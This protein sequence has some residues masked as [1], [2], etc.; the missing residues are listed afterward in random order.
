MLHRLDEAKLWGAPTRKLDR[1]AAGLFRT[2]NLQ[3]DGRAEHLSIAATR[4]AFCTSPATRQWLVSQEAN[5]LEC[6][7]RLGVRDVADP[8]PC[9]ADDDEN[10]EST[11]NQNQTQNK[12][13]RH[14]WVSFERASC[15]LRRREPRVTLKNGR[16]R[17]PDSLM[18][19]VLVDDFRAEVSDALLATQRRLKFAQA[20]A[21]GGGAFGTPVAMDIITRLVRWRP[22]RPTRQ[23]NEA[24]VRQDREAAREAARLAG[25]DQRIQGT[26]R[27]LNSLTHNDALANVPHLPQP[28]T[29]EIEDL[30]VDGY[31]F[32]ANGG[33]GGNAEGHD[34]RVRG[35]WCRGWR[36]RRRDAG[37]APPA[38]SLTTYGV[39][40]GSL[41]QANDSAFGALPMEHFSPPIGVDAKRALRVIRKGV[42]HT[43]ASSR[44][45]PLCVRR[46]LSNLHKDHHLKHEQ[47]FQL[48]LFFKGIDLSAEETLHVWRQQFNYGKMNDFQNEHRYHVRHAFGL[49]GK[50]ADYPP[51]TCEKLGA[52]KVYG[53]AVVASCPF[54]A[55]RGGS[56]NSGNDTLNGPVN[57]LRDDLSNANINHVDAESIVDIAQRGDP[58]S[59]CVAFFKATHGVGDDRPAELTPRDL[60][61][62]HDYYDKSV[63]VEGLVTKGEKG[64]TSVDAG[65]ATGTRPWI[66]L[67]L[68]ED[69]DDSE[70]E[71]GGEVGHRD[72]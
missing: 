1:L 62:P 59:A 16:A 45:F 44:A 51:F 34:G 8:K 33:S 22:A 4:L 37:N 13:E 38:T 11:P 24:W 23:E 54:A 5:L 30:V 58:R 66:T 57:S 40:N 3:S 2:G 52:R 35:G 65:N 63:C 56:M 17:V 50:M 39:S 36:R 32:G 49:E 70:D 12:P 6:R 48:T 46:Q 41:Q 26:D 47:R 9:E 31:F 20:E 27:Q 15:L 72:H 68:E 7:F 18:P 67:E 60:K 21:R 19:E 55:A 10:D 29:D 14:R 64:A 42:H 28:S 69:T 71:G 53:G 25:T 43:K 61:F